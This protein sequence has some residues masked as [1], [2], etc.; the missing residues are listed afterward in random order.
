[1]RTVALL[2][3]GLWLLLGGVSNPWFIKSWIHPVKAPSMW[4]LAGLLGAACWAIAAFAAMIDA[5]KP[6][7][8]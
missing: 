7:G 6:R 1:L 5:F 3:A 8:A 2:H 4:I